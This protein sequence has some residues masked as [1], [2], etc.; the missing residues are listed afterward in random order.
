MPL[1][2]LTAAA[3][4]AAVHIWAG[5]PRSKAGDVSSSPTID[6][7]VVDWQRGHCGHAA[8]GTPDCAGGSEGSWVL[9]KGAAKSWEA[10]AAECKER[11]EGCARC[12]AV[13]LSLKYRDC[14]WFSECNTSALLHEVRGFRSLR[15]RRN[16]GDDRKRIFLLHIPKVA[17]ASLQSDVTQL[18][19][20][21]TRLLGGEWIRPERSET[22]FPAVVASFPRLDL[23]TVM[24][25]S[26]RH[27][28]VSMFSHCRDNPLAHRLMKRL[29]GEPV[30][31][32][33]FG[34][35]RAAGLGAWLSH[36]ASVDRSVLRTERKEAE[37]SYGCYDPF[38]LQTRALTCSSDRMF[39]SHRGPVGTAQAALSNALA[40]GVV[41]GVVEL[42]RASLCA[43]LFR[44]SQTLL[45]GCRCGAGGSAPAAPLGLTKET[46]GMKETAHT[47]PVHALAPG[48]LAA[49]D[50]V[51]ALDRE[52]F[53]AVALRAIDDMRDVERSASARIVCADELRVLLRN[54]GSY[55][56]EV[57][58]RVESLL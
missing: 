47:L 18:S 7:S 53:S 23:R 30:F 29:Q 52:V 42:Y 8:A 40:T 54:V 45:D 26:P 32:S 20:G 14:S 15:L 24:V 1:T 31:T 21:H 5:S 33:R 39:A 16:Q 27:H 35:S 56:P 43:I 17:G 55:V 46:H 49:M 41:L 9:G 36:H 25:R 48:L 44:V 58:Q 38:N 13:S 19:R 50:N 51:T 37:L 57:R 28:V 12:S 34:G 10:A 11:C 3:A 4:T 2:A 6:A 22:C